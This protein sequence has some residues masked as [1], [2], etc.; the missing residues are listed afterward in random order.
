MV[1][2]PVRLPYLTAILG[3]LVAPVRRP[4]VRSWEYFLLASSNGLPL[5]CTTGI[6]TGRGPG[7]GEK[8]LNSIRFPAIRPSCLTKGSAVCSFLS[9]AAPR[10]EEHTSELQS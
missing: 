1:C 4:G 5:G 6:E 9:A 3:S 7:G 8:W 2:T 10:S